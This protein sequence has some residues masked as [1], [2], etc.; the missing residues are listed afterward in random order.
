MGFLAAIIAFAFCAFVYVRMIRR[1]VPEQIGKA[2]AW[3]PVTVGLIA[4]ILSSALALGSGLLVF[5]LRGGEITGTEV[6]SPAQSNLSPLP[7]S[8][9]SAFLTAGLPEEL[10]KL[11]LA[12]LMV[13]IFKPKNVYEYAL[14][15]TGVGAGFTVLEEALYSGGGF[16]SLGRL[17]TFAMHMVLGL[18]MGVALGHA[19]YFRQHGG[20]AGKYILLGLILPVLWHTIYDAGT[21]SNAGFSEEVENIPAAAIIAGAVVVLA[22]VVLQFALLIRFKN[23]AAEFSG[24]EL[25]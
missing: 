7:R 6:I 15:F 20:N 16:I 8:L 11:L 13:K 19:R 2:Q 1:E 5:K 25:K 3:V 22:S 14:A 12:L 18:V 17:V 10:V 24:M 9:L 23:K 4:P 21:A